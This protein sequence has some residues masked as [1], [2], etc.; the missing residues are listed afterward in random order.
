MN[1]IRSG[2]FRPT[3]LTMLCGLTILIAATLA[4]GSMAQDQSG[5]SI[6]M[7]SRSFR[8]E[9][10]AHGN[11]FE[12]IAVDQ[13]DPLDSEIVH[14]PLPGTLVL[15]FGELKNKANPA[16]EFASLLSEL[17]R[18]TEHYEVDAPVR[19]VRINVS[20]AA[21]EYVISLIRK[22]SDILDDTGVLTSRDRMQLEIQL[23]AAS[24]TQAG[25]M[26]AVREASRRHTEI[27][28]RLS[29]TGSRQYDTTSSAALWPHAARVRP[30]M[31]IVLRVP[32]T[33]SSE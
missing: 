16:S 13:K 1:A 26:D 23:W 7:V 19:E 31:T 30:T 22:S 3:T 8:A 11:E 14:S 32:V 6:A 25:W 15:S 33:Y 2:I 9:T 17:E 18:I 27:D 21:V 29:A 24:P 12:L 20:E 5:Q 28:R 4:L 10:G